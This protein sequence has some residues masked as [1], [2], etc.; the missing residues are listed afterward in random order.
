MSRSSLTE[1]LRLPIF[2]YFIAWNFFLLSVLGVHSPRARLSLAVH[3]TIEHTIGQA[4]ER[5]RERKW[6]TTAQ[7]IF[8]YISWTVV[9]IL[10]RRL[11]RTPCA[12]C[13]ELKRILA[14]IQKLSAEILLHVRSSVCPHTQLQLHNY[15]P[16]AYIAEVNWYISFEFKRPTVWLGFYSGRLRYMYRVFDHTWLH[17]H[18]HD[19]HHRFTISHRWVCSLC[20][21]EWPLQFL[22]LFCCFRF[23]LFSS[24][25]K[26][27]TIIWFF[28]S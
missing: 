13:T 9:F 11:L 16:N 18:H 7:R 19:H 5:A 20:R 25:W 8:E 22:F 23:R 15:T 2:S 21:F 28:C 6:I 3:T 1:F 26:G 27:N 12:L 4:W 10:L 24:L 14:S 17:L